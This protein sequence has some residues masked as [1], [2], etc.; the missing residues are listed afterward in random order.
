MSLFFK[1]SPFTFHIM[2]PKK[3]ISQSH[4]Y[5]R[6]SCDHSTAKLRLKSDK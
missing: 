4:S 6:H 1:K 2:K 3:N 5:L